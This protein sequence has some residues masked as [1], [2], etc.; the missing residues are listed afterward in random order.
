MIEKMYKKIIL[1]SFVGLA[2]LT[3]NVGCGKK[4]EGDAGQ[5]QPSA[6]A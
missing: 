3:S 6:S 4:T 2:M 5:A 1:S